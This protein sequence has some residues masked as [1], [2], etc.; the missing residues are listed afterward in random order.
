MCKASALLRKHGRCVALSPEGSP[1]V[2]F[3]VRMPCHETRLS[4]ARNEQPSG[5]LTMKP[6]PPQTTYNDLLTIL[7]ALDVGVF[8]TDADCT[9]L[10]VN[11]QFEKVTTV[12]RNEVLGKNTQYMLDNNYIAT[13][14]CQH[15]AKTEK[16]VVDILNYKNAGREVIVT[17]KPIFQG[18][19]LRYIVCTLRDW[20]LLTG[21][22]KELH[23]AKIQNMHY[24]ETLQTLEMQQLEDSEYIA[25]DP[26]TK[27]MLQMAVRVA[28]GDSTVLLLGESGVGKDRLAKFIHKVGLRQK[29]GRFVHVNCGAI[30]EALFEAEFFGYAPGAFT[31]ANKTGKPGLLEIAYGGTLFLDEIGELPLFMQA[32]LLKVLQDR[33]FTPVGGIKESKVDLK[34]V[35]ATNKNLESMVESGQFRHD[36]YYR[37]NVFNIVVPSLCERKNDIP[38]LLSLL[39]KRFNAKYN[40]NKT[41]KPEA[42]EALL[43]Y[44][45]PGN[46]R[47]LEHTL[48]RLVVLCT[49]DAIGMEH[50]P[51]CFSENI[52]LA[53]AVR[54]AGTQPLKTILE[55]VERAIILDSIEKTNTLHDAARLLGIDLST[56]TRK[57]QKHG[58]FKNA[59]P[60]QEH[61][62][63]D[64]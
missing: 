30:P 17:G 43:N 38:P 42:V 35:A 48:E 2:I 58:I 61:P 32:K 34:V 14:I 25:Y 44:N 4:V 40:Q 47:E 13:S 15:V 22:Y 60:D 21:L 56:L 62:L 11:S 51:G 23:E 19:S 37:L 57:K 63:T 54:L 8:I 52:L 27:K 36:L 55:Q 64:S 59:G 53:K 41:L 33:S 1:D 12:S 18:N 7:D 45:W 50:L 26:K 3:P 9:I 49:E 28:K 5:G 46:I 16:P 24:K 6:P 29:T 10:A 20:N 39:L 31:G